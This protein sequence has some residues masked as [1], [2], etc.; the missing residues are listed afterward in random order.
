MDRD[1]YLLDVYHYVGMNRVSAKLVQHSPHADLLVHAHQNHGLERWAPAQPLP[2]CKIQERKSAPVWTP[3]VNSARTKYKIGDII[4]ITITIPE[5]RLA[6]AKIFENH[7]FGVFGLWSRTQERLEAI[8]S[9]PVAF[10]VSG[11]DAAIKDGTW[12]V[13]GHVP[14]PHA[15]TD[16]SYPP[17]VAICYDY[18]SGEW[19][20]GRPMATHKGTEKFVTAREVKGLDRLLFCHKPELVL[21]TIVDRLIDGNHAYYQVRPV[22]AAP[23]PR[24]RCRRVPPP[25]RA[26]GAQRRTRTTMPATGSRALKKSR[27]LVG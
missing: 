1:A 4:T 17:P 7:S 15:D 24:C 2:L 10:F 26:T 20:M 16:A 13:I 18:D 11:T 5:G 12:P 9:H 19:T 27:I 8:A 3:M 14:F 22:V 25:P 6:Y 23:R 21:A